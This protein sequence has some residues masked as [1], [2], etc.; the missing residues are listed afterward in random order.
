MR[1][2]KAITA[3]QRAALEGLY[4]QGAYVEERQRSHCILLSSAGKSMHELAIIFGVSRLTISN[5]LYK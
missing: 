2:I 4:K 3:E 5:W 1:Y